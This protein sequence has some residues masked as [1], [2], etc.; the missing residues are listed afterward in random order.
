MPQK[1]KK[2]IL[3]TEDYPFGNS[4]R[5]FLKEEI[6]YLAKEF[7]QVLIAPIRV[8]EGVSFDLPA[9]VFGTKELA[10]K[11]TNISLR[12]KLRSLFSVDLIKEFWNIRFNPNRIKVAISRHLAG[13]VIEDWIVEELNKSQAKAVLYSYWFNESALGI[14]KVQRQRNYLKCISRCHNFDLYGNDETGNY[15]PFQS[16]VLRRLTAIYPVSDDGAIFLNKKFGVKAEPR[17]LGVPDPY[18]LN[19]VSN[20]RMIR[21]ASCS[22]MVPRKRVDLIARGLISFCEKNPKMMVNWVHFGDGPDKVQVEQVLK[23]SPE[24]FKGE[25]LGNLPNEQVLNYYKTHPIDLFINSSKKE[26]TPVS[27][28][29]AISFGIPVMATKFG[30][31]TE[32]VQKGAGVLLPLDPS[33]DEFVRTFNDFLSRDQKALRNASREVWDNGYNSQKNYTHFCVELAEGL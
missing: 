26:G 17:F 14:S 27:I 21:V 12:T 11:L 25:L 32:V 18:V 20:N 13:I 31:N 15:V 10:F 30:G 22:Y 5:S 24:N 4:E 28:M 29:E 1:G 19:P 8:F 3:F 7:D 16:I 2:L 6:H 33:E 9:N 23:K